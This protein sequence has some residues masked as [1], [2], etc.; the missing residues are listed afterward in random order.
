MHHAQRIHFGYL[1]PEF[2]TN[3]FETTDDVVLGP[4]RAFL[5]P[6]PD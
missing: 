2:E 5:D 3:P 6:T 1:E 4:F